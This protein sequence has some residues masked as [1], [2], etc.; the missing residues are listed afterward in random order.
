MEELIFLFRSFEGL[1]SM[2]T[3]AGLLLMTIIAFA[4][5]STLYDLWEEA[6]ETGKLH[7]LSQ[8]DLLRPWLVRIYQRS[9]VY[10]TFGTILFFLALTILAQLLFR[11]T[12]PDTATSLINAILIFRTIAIILANAAIFIGIFSVQI[13]LRAE[14]RDLRKHFP[15][16]N[17]QLE[18]L[19]S[20]YASDKYFSLDHVS[21]RK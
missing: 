3:F 6:V 2:T 18:H 15:T 4:R 9:R 12:P 21:K 5:A 8:K 1:L 13:G 16:Y 17:I 11:S 14:L 19:T 20:L 7:K 10:R